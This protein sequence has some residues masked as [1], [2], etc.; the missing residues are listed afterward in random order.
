MFFDENLLLYNE[1]AKALY[2]KVRNLPIVDYHCHLG[3]GKIARND[4]FSDIG[5]LWLSGDHYKW[6]LIFNTCSNYMFCCITR[7]LCYNIV[8]SR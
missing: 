4:P 2:E 5:E 3:A 1:T 6:R 8:V 7:F